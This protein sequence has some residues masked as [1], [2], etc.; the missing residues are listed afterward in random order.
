MRQPFCLKISCNRSQPRK[1]P[2]SKILVRLVSIS[3]PMGLDDIWKTNRPG[4]WQFTIILQSQLNISIVGLRRLHAAEKEFLYKR[5][6][7][8]CYEKPF[9]SSSHTF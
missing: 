9:V 4:V 6:A 2:P 1:K 7:S 3:S 5:E 8:G